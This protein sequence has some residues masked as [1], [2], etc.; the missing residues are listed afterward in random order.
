M[1]TDTDEVQTVTQVETVTQT[2]TVTVPTTTTPPPPPPP[3]P[4]TT[5]TTTPPPPPP[6]A[7]TMTMAQFQSAC[8]VSGALIENVTVTGSGTARCSGSNVTV[9]N[10][11]LSGF[12]LEPNANGFSLI[13]STLTGGK[14]G[15]YGPDNG[16]LE[17]NTLDG[18]GRVTSN[19]FED[20][21]AGNGCQ[22]WV[23][24]GN[25]IKNYRGVDCLTHGEG[26]RIGGYA[27][28]FLIEGNRFEQNGCTSHIF[29]TYWGAAGSK[30]Y[31]SAQL[32][33]NICVRENDFGPLFRETY[34]DINFRQ[35][36]YQAGPAATNIRI[37]PD[38]GASTTRAEFN[39][40]C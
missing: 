32:P 19:A 13:G 35:E 12:N 30:G 16:L 33:R 2:V 29:F 37:D 23:I 1:L 34:V 38:Q 27:N 28:N 22:N 36:V 14:F 39:I 24:R 11:T 25:L 18:Q 17:N 15:C 31:Q 10:A 6:P 20:Y 4:P 8:A 26:L 7:T 5:T 40:N 9:K 3:P 21:P